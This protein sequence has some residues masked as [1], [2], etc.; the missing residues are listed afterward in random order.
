MIEF[1][2]RYPSKFFTRLGLSLGLI[3]FIA[4]Y[5]FLLN[6]FQGFDFST[7]EFNT[8]WLSFDA[9][10]FRDFIAPLLQSGKLEIF[11]NTFELNILSISAFM[12]A[13]YCL[14]LMIARSFEPTSKLYKIAYLFPLFP[15][16]IAIFDIVPSILIAVASNETLAN[17]PSWL[18]YVVSGGYVIRVLLLYILFIWFL[19]A[20][21]R[22]IIRKL[23]KDKK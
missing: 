15:I 21:I 17:F 23:K 5:S 14:S 6:L 11:K 18:A 16:L 2:K 1:F 10:K 19:F 3:V 12:I 4:I 22:F 13:F 7:G 8:V 9:E 20:L